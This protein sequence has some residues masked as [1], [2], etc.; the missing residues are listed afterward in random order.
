MRK[1]AY[2]YDV[3]TYEWQVRGACASHGRR[4]PGVIRTSDRKQRPAPT[5]EYFSSTS[6]DNDVFSHRTRGHGVVG[7]TIIICC[8]AVR[9]AAADIRATTGSAPTAG[10]LRIDRRK[11]G[12]PI[13]I[14]HI[15]RDYSIR[16]EIDAT[17]IL[18]EIKAIFPCAP[19]DSR[20][21]NGLQCRW[22]LGSSSRQI[23]KPRRRSDERFDFFPVRVCFYSLVGHEPVSFTRCLAV[24]QVP[25]VNAKMFLNNIL[26]V[27]CNL[28]TVTVLVFSQ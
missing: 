2:V 8:S 9:T 11:N 22:H 18:F 5:G 3:S 19:S 4:E 23:G 24:I 20:R 1:C 28:L 16:P 14:A 7:I 17:R 25:Y 26:F 27:V 10:W 6:R 12:R 15:T 13:R 21:W